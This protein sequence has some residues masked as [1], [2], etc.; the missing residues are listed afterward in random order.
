MEL[1]GGSYRRDGRFFGN[2]RWAKPVPG[3]NR[4]TLRGPPG[5][6]HQPPLLSAKDEEISPIPERSAELIRRDALRLR[7]ASTINS[8]YRGQTAANLLAAS[9]M[10]AHSPTDSSVIAVS[11]AT[12][13]SR[14]AAGGSARSRSDGRRPSPRKV[15]EWV[16]S[17][18]TSLSTRTSPL[19]ATLPRPHRGV[20][21]HN[22]VMLAS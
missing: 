15:T 16:W 13:P 7:R 22:A 12:L 3:P 9:Q 18:A 14:T 17:D 2:D 20:F 8:T 6:D 1:V 5:V 10:P 21:N 11:N 4:R 19:R